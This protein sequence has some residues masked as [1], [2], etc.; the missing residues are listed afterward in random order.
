MMRLA[1]ELLGVAAFALLMTAAFFYWTQIF[2]NG[3]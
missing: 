2:P 3:M 1:L